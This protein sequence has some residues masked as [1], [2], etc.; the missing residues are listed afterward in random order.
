MTPEQK[1]EPI[2]PIDDPVEALRAELERVQPPAG[3]VARIRQRID[4][5]AQA[6]VRLA[7]WRWAM[8]MA[9]IA[10]VL[11]VVSVTRRSVVT[12]TEPIS[13]YVVAS[14]QSTTPVDPARSADVARPL[15]PAPKPGRVTGSPP[16]DPLPA[17]PAPEVITH[18]ADV[19][20]SLWAHIGPNAALVDAPSVRP[21]IATDIVVTP[22]EV[23]PIVIKPPNEGKASEAPIVRLPISDQVKGSVQ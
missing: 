17:S 8:P 20:Q 23:E 3:Y 12:P 5:E 19:L 9:S 10:I 22:I 1:H 15:P 7:W 6:P 4:A 18:Q 21:D 11:V 16:V 13:K 14:G 2:E